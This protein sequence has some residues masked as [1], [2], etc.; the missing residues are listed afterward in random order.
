MNHFVSGDYHWRLG[1][2]RAEF[3]I[4][5]GEAILR[6]H[7]SREKKQRSGSN[8]DFVLPTHTAKS[9]ELC[10][11][12]DCIETHNSHRTNSKQRGL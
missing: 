8:H 3:Q 4:S 6:N 9:L 7:S 11:P 2:S 5:S 10:L 12:T 1:I